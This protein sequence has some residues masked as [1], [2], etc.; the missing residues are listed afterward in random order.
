M[1]SGRSHTGHE[2]LDM[3]VLNRFEGLAAAL[4]AGMLLGFAAPAA[5]AG[6]GLTGPSS[7][8][9][10]CSTWMG[11]LAERERFNLRNATARKSGDRVVVEYV[12]YGKSPTRCEAKPSGVPSNPFVGKLVYQELRYERSGASKDGALTGQPRVLSSTEVMEIFRF[13]GSRWVY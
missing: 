7:F 6:P 3:R 12:G 8:E 13:D 10:F 11:K 4:C 5:H 2:V 1:V 9:R